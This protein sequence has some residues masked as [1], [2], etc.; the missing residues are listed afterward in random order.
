MFSQVLI[1]HTVFALGFARIF[2]L[3]FWVGSFKELVDHGGSK[4]P[5]YFIHGSQIGHLALMI[6]FFYYYFQSLSKGI[7][8]ALPTTTN[9][10]SN[11]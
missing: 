6:D 2:E 1:G 9:L 8:M 3:L 11:V 7:P 10:S 4:T 5:G